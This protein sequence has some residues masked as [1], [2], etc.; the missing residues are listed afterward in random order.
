M[1]DN[2]VDVIIGTHPHVLQPI[3]WLTNDD[4][5]KT[6]C[7]YSLGNMISTM[8]YSHNMVGGIV[9]FDIIKEGNEKPYVSLVLMTP[10][11]CHYDFRRRGL[12]VYKL[13]DYTPELSAEHGAQKNRTFTFESLID[14]VTSHVDTSFLPAYYAA[15]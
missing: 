2:N 14:V 8:L 5:Y 10:V 9:T 13:E 15:N 11:M 6:L 12:E 3:E 7:I 4:G 1:N